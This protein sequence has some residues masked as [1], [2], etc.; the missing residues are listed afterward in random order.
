MIV[1]PD[2][3]KFR[4]RTEDGNGT[5][6]PI[7]EIEEYWSGRYLASAEAA[8]RILGYHITQ[9]TP[10][11]TAL[12]VHLPDS[13][14]YQRYHRLKPSPT[15]SNLEHY[16][17]RPEGFFLD[18]TDRRYFKD[19]RYTEYF[20]RFRIQKF[21]EA[22]LNK[23]GFF[24][25]RQTH[26]G[27]P[28]MHVVQRN[29][30]RPH[31]TRLQT[32]HITRGEL[33]YLRSLLLSR[34]GISWTDLQTIDGIVHP[35]FQAAC[36]A[37]GLFTDRNEAQVCMQEAVET[38][39]TPQQLRILFVHLLTNSCIST[40][41][42]FWTDFR[43]EIAKDFISDS[44]GDIERG[45]NDALKT[46]GSLLQSHGKYLSDY[47]LPQPIT[48]DNEVERELRRWSSQTTALQ[49]QVHAGLSAFTPEQR[50]IFLQV[51]YAI[52]N[53]E[54]LLMFVD[55]KAGRGKTFLVNTLCAW[56]RSTGRIALPTA[57]SAFAAQLYLGGKTTHSTF[58]VRLH[59][60]AKLSSN[61]NQVPV[62][63]RNEFLESTIDPQHQRAELLRRC[64]LI[65]WDEAPMAN[66]AVLA[67][68]EECCRK[69]TGNQIP[70]G[71]K[72]VILLG[73]FRQTCPVVPRGTKADV[74]NACISR[75]P[76]W[77]L[78]RISR[79]TVPIRNAD[80]PAFASFVD[81]IG[82]GAGPRIDLSFLAHTTNI[83]DVISF[84]YDQSILNNPDACLR[85]C[86]LAPTNAQV[87]LYNNAVLNL[88]T[89]T[90]RQYQAADSLEEHTEVTEA[91]GIDLNDDSPLPNPDAV[92]DYVRHR[93]PNGMPDYNLTIKVGGVYR[94]LR[95]LSI[96]L[97]L[98][99]NARVVIV[100]T[101]SKLITIR[102]L[103]STHTPGTNSNDILLPR[104]TFK[105]RLLSGH[106]LCRR[107]FPL[108][109]AYAS[110]FHS[111]QGLTLDCVG[112]DLTQDVFTHGQLYTALSRIRHRS[113]AIVRF[114]TLHDF[115]TPNVTYKE[116]LI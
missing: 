88:L 102:L 24:L 72:V 47:G 110:T 115:T 80:D 32:V 30:S 11:V 14:H 8:W 111:C 22:D 45:C 86:I 94:L 5:E 93:R 65:I 83:D 58:G 60:I 109:A 95:N 97:G 79:L 92:L 1:G 28:P 41:L 13:P 106:T 10:S 46:L 73:D 42:Q 33:F 48:H 53:N 69:V 67:C 51:Q 71:G 39:R 66:C 54:P 61:I 85:R 25:E 36:I 99:K 91:T 44:R 103:Q 77:P 20:A 43:Y 84:V 116:L 34:P 38:F 17:A 3:A 63:E 29:P 57:T 114:P 101:G 55:G 23:P 50:D 2:R 104:I 105:D 64:D 56:V 35:S 12:P 59:L 108:S 7:D 16:F 113:H 19:L 31:L 6:G 90:S 4:I 9:K 75:C 70:F 21:H 96:N 82:D 81:E 37:L 112:I 52:L 62:N 98:V 18:G 107:Q 78:F 76:L 15:L 49:L 27:A 26:E 100:G 74:L 40:P 89:S 68:V 87:D